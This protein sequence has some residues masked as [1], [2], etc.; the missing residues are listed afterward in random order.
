MINEELS[1]IAEDFT[2]ELDYAYKSEDLL[3]VTTSWLEREALQNPI[4]IPMP[5]RDH[6]KKR[7]TVLLDI[8]R[9]VAVKNDDIRSD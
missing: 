1:Q 5:G 9:R 8:Q 4:R 2:H 3:E 6:F 7:A